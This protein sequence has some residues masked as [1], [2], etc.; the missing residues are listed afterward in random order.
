[1]LGPLGIELHSLAEFSQTKDLE[2][3]ETAETFAGN[4]ALKAQAYFEQLKL[5]VLADDSGLEVLALNNQP[6]VA[7]NR[8]YQGSDADR[9]A[10][11][12]Q[13]L[14]NVSD[15]RARFVTVLCLL[16][17]RE[18]PI[19]FRGEVEGIIAREP[20]G[21]DGFGYD[22]IFIP[23]G[24]SQT[25]AEMGIAVKNTLSHRA[26]ALIQLQEYLRSKNN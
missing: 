26:R 12:L 17:Q 5:P 14:I 4:A 3:A 7:S 16:E 23:E 1:M 6:G 15:R 20:R 18:Q 13:R 2:V 9:N 19:F 11:L 21:V 22:P 25:F 8:W 10:A 24:Y